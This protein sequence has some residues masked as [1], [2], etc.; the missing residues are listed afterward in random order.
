MFNLLTGTP[1]VPQADIVNIIN[2]PAIVQQVKQEL[3]VEEKIK[4]NYYK[5]NTDI[6][7]IRAD[8]AQC[9]DKTQTTRRKPS[10]QPQNSPQGGSVGLNGY[11][12]GQCTA[13][14]AQ[15]RYVPAGWGNASDWKY[16]AEAA[17][18]T[19]SPTPIVGAIAWRYGHVAYVIGV[20]DGVV[21]ISEQNYDWNSGIRTITIPVGDYLYIYE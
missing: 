16:N 20:G 10:K 19:V 17:G 12:L 18:W 1:S 2:K 7:W 3:T 4:T 5:C 8:N 13:W 11:E 21:T 15:H 6:Q 14:V 9:L